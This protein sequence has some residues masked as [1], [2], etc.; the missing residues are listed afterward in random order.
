MVTAFSTALPPAALPA[1]AT[2][3]VSVGTPLVIAMLVAA[4]VAI[5]AVLE[6]RGNGG[7]DGVVGHE[8]VRSRERWHLAPG[9]PTERLRQAAG[10]RSLGLIGCPYENSTWFPSGSATMQK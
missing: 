5:G 9:S 2:V 4:L 8:E 7:V 6:V 10:G 1:G 3:L